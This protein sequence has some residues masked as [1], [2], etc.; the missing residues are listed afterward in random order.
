MLFFLPGALA[1]SSTVTVFS[2]APARGNNR[3]A[4]SAP[5]KECLHEQFLPTYGVDGV[6][7]PWCIEWFRP[8]SLRIKHVTGR[9]STLP[10]GS[11]AM[12]VVEGSL[13]ATGVCSLTRAAS[14]T[15]GT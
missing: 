8:N 12:S 1:A 3:T 13:R 4:R 9:G 7:A 15:N 6:S 5:A 14:S 10:I 11:T 2:R